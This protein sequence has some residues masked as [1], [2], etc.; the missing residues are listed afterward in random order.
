ML[1]WDC[2]EVGKNDAANLIN[3]VFG[4]RVMSHRS[5][6]WLAG[7]AV[8]AGALFSSPVM[9]TARKGIFEPGQLQLHQGHDRLRLGLHRGHR[10]LHA[11]SAYGNAVSTTASLIFELVGAALGV[12]F[13]LGLV[14]GTRSAR[15]S[16]PSGCPSCSPA[17]P[18]FLVQ[19]VFRAAIQD[20]TPTICACCC[21]ARGSPACCSPGCRGS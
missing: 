16:T 4:A 9:E 3:G 10:A 2:L 18:V 14:I 1:A 20:G 6:V 19:R 15:F 8:L 13:S 5:A 11:Y 7:A 21:T 17:S 12:S